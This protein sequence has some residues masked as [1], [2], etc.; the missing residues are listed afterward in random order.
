VGYR[1]RNVSWLGKLGYVAAKKAQTQKV[2][3]S[4]AYFSV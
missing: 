1:C 3:A 2:V 4:A